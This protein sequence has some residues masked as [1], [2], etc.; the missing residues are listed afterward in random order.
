MLEVN[1][2]EAAIMFKNLPFGGDPEGANDAEIKEK[3]IAE[4]KAKGLK[5]LPEGWRS[6]SDEEQEAYIEEE[7]A[8]DKAIESGIAPP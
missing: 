5:L 6:M 1:A 3:F 8:R 7:K 2:T 4:T